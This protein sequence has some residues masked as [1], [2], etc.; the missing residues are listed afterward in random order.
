MELIGTPDFPNPIVDPVSGLAITI[1]ATQQN[2]PGWWAQ[3]PDLYQHILDLRKQYG[4]EVDDGIAAWEASV[5]EA[6]ASYEP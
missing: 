4:I 2:Y 1:P 3:Q 5:E 6:R